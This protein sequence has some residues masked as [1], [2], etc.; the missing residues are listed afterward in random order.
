MWPVD[1]WKPFD[2]K[3]FKWIFD[4][5]QAKEINDAIEKETQQRLDDIN[6]DLEL[7]QKRLDWSIAE[8]WRNLSRIQIWKWSAEELTR[9]QIQDYLLTELDSLKDFWNEASTI[10][11]EQQQEA[12]K[13]LEAQFEEERKIIINSTKPYEQKV[14]E[15]E[16][17]EQN[18]TRN[19]LK[20]K[21]EET[22]LL[23][24]ENDLQI[25]KQ[26]EVN[27]IVTKFYEEQK[28]AFKELQ[29]KNNDKVIESVKTITDALDDY[30]EWINK[31]EE[32]FQELREDATKSIRDI[33]NEITDL[34]Q[35]QVDV[36][37][38]FEKS[39]LKRE[40]EL[41][42]SETD[43][44]QQIQQ[45]RIRGI[46]N[47]PEAEKQL[48][49]VRQELDQIRQVRQD[50]V[51]TGEL[52]QKTETQRLLEQR[53]IEQENLWKQRETLDERL[54]LLRAS[55]QDRK[56]IIEEEGEEIS[57][58]YENERWEIVKLVDF[59]NIQE[60]LA[61]EEKRAKLNEEFE[62][63]KQNYNKEIEAFKDKIAIQKQE[64]QS[65]NEFLKEAYKNR[66]DD[67]REHL[68]KLREITRNNALIL[69]ESTRQI[70]DNR[71]L[72]N[73]NNDN[74]IIN[75]YSVNNIRNFNVSNIDAEW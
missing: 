74:R 46:F 50:F 5:S 65:L 25:K 20:I 67:Y 18:L 1:L 7:R 69:P 56:I 51:I 32:G 45:N 64:E 21:W 30:V 17:L 68:T 58:F 31:V 34:N 12:I 22:K 72:T 71:N 48:K 55:R 41:R 42:Q 15:I 59:K 26:E 3:D 13:Q 9:W 6:T 61:I 75:D 38:T 62:L 43:I 63:V 54:Q 23:A 44:L 47:D 40:Q 49:N 24:F 8:I 70:L 37:N 39:I 57:A 29:E 36:D 14:K 33:K 53:R 2:D 4:G 27:D 28:E 60:A 52:E 10:R 19:I 35:Q 11:E 66:E 16:E 73:N